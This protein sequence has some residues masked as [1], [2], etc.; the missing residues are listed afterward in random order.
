MQ[1]P[2]FHIFGDGEPAETGRGKKNGRQVLF[3]YGLRGGG[4]GEWNVTPPTWVP[5]KAG[6]MA[7]HENSSSSSTD[8]PLKSMFR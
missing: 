7:R 4:M 6:G 2:S 1:P 3:S 5:L 8:N